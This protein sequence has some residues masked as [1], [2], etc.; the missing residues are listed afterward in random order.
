MKRKILFYINTLEHGGA[1]RVLSNLAN[2]FFEA[3]ND[4]LFVTS[5]S[6]DNEY[7]LNSGITRINL[8]TNNLNKKNPLYRNFSRTK[9]LSDI[10]QEE[11][12][13]LV[14]SFLP[15]SNFRAIIA[16]KRNRIPVIVSVRNDPEH[17]YKSKSYYLAQKFLYPLVSGMVFQTEDAKNWF[18]KKI[19]VKSEIIMNQINPVFYEYYNNSSDYFV[20]VGRLS[21]QKNYPFLI[22]VFAKFVEK[23]PNEVLH[24]Y[25]EGNLK[26]ILQ[27]QIENKHMENNI[28]LMGLSNNIPAV[29]SHAKAF[30]MTSKYEGMPNALVEAMAVGVPVISTDC[31]CGGPKMLIKHKENG[32]LV[33]VNNEQELLNALLFV[34]ENKSECAD[35]KKRAKSFAKQF[36]PEPVFR[37]WNDYVEKVLK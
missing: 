37:K 16:A 32:F 21:E 34:E 12:P 9:R 36:K 7:E 3:Q 6:V 1:E 22:N 10:L 33:N 28:R 14:I 27:E 35:I 17:E 2:Q 23:Y 31:P 29:L 24:I 18:P 5:Y 19:Q 20:A 25:G 8:E 13:D 30:I 4:I 11:K 26:D 15:E